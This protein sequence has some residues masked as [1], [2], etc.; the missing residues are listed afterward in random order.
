MKIPVETFKNVYLG[1]HGAVFDA[2]KNLIFD[3]R[4]QSHEKPSIEFN[5]SREIIQLPEGKYI[6]LLQTHNFPVWGHFSE[7]LSALYYFE[8]NNINECTLIMNKPQF[9]HSTTSLS[10]HMA[11]FGYPVHRLKFI[12]VK[13]SYFQ[14]PELY[15]IHKIDNVSTKETC[16]YMRDAW[17]KNCSYDPEVTVSKLYLSRPKHR[18]G[19]R[20]AINES[21]VIDYL[22]PQG[23]TVFTGEEGFS[24]H[25]EM[26]QN[27]DIIIGP[28]GAAFFNTILCNKDP[29]ILEFC[30]EQRRVNMFELQS[31]LMGR[32]N[33]HLITVPCNTQLQFNIDINI[34]NSYI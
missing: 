8:Q 29:L 33:H 12:N 18:I 23:F 7:L 24:R 10:Y 19:S 17:Y 25:I 34:V 26:F 13:K 22:L 31:K 27:A 30:P 32:L 11:V 14:V 20:D 6:N 1:S 2:D 21:E 28:H 4:E 3:P 5:T 9:G 15:C 16:N